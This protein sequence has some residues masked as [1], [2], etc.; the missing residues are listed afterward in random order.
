MEKIKAKTTAKWCRAREG[1]LK[2]DIK[3][4]LEKLIIEERTKGNDVDICIGT[5]S[6]RARPGF[7]YATVI[8]VHVKRLLKNEMVGNGSKVIYKRYFDSVKKDIVGRMLNEVHETLEVYYEIKDLLEKHNIEPEIHLDINANPDYSS[9]KAYSQA[10][11][12]VQGLGLKFQVKPNAF[13]A[14]SCA[15]KLV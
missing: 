12:W 15:D 6:Q 9:N 11:G 8:I 4:Y 5:D 13:A 10:V 7:K 1:E 3:S 14:S 2:V